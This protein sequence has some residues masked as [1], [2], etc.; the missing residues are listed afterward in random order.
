MY[1][2]VQDTVSRL[3]TALDKQVAGWTERP[4]PVWVLNAMHVKIRRQ[5]AVQ[6]TTLM[7][8]VGIDEAGRRE[9]LERWG[10][11]SKLLRS[12]LRLSF[13]K[14]HRPGNKLDMDFSL[15]SWLSAV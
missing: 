8:A 4:P 3:T 1:A 9:I 14:R 6:S 13:L 7:L 2:D 12:N 15:N 5:G 10:F 11:D